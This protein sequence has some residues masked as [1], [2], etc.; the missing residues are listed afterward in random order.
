MAR[1][2]EMKRRQLPTEH[3]KGNR[4]VSVGSSSFIYQPSRPE[5]KSRSRPESGL[6]RLYSGPLFGVGI[7]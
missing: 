3:A 2:E 7:T 4:R 6:S 1:K 5:K